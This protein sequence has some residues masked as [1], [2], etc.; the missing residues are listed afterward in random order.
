M[1]PAQIIRPFLAEADRRKPHLRIDNRF[2]SCGELLEDTLALAGPDFQFIGKSSH[3]GE[4]GFRPAWFKPQSVPC[5]RPDGQTENVLIDLLGMDAAWYLP[6][7]RQVKVLTNST[8][9]ELPIGDSRRG[10]AGLD[11]YD[12]SPTNP[13]TGEPHYR[14]HNPPMPQS[15]ITGTPMP[16]P[17]PVPPPATHAG[18]LPGREEALDELNFLDRYYHSREGLDRQQGLSIAGAPDFEGV[19][20]WYLD[21]YQNERLKGASREQ[22]RAAYIK[23]IRNSNEWKSKHPGETP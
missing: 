4:A 7:G 11:S 13:D 17:N 18:S 22:A 14:W 2:A 21:V 12:I 23:N 8:A 3:R 19:A 9:N 16:T 1:T 10:P 15:G 6:A 5:R 20:A